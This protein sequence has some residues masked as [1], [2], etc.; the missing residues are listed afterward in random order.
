MQRMAWQPVEEN[1]KA[2]IPAGRGMRG[3]TAEKMGAMSGDK[4]SDKSNQM[5]AKKGKM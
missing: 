3:G 5:D 1:S 2:K 4:P